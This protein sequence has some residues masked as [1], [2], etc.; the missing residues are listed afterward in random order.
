MA[1]TKTLLKKSV[2]INYEN[3]ATPAQWTTVEM[4]RTQ[5]YTDSDEPDEPWDVTKSFHWDRDT[6]SSATQLPNA[7]QT[8]LINH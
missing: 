5:R 4:L 3:S 7:L 2:T 1:I 8:Y 6:I